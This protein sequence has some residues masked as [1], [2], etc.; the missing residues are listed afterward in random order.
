MK[1]LLTGMLTAA[2]CVS[3]ATTA[4]A[5][6]INQDSNDKTGSTTLTT[7]KA[8]TYTVVIPETAEITFDVEENPIG[9]IT[10]QSGNLEPDAYVTVELTE[11]TVLANQVDETYTIDYEIKSGDAAFE[12]IVYDEDT[13]AGTKTELT[14]NITKEAWENAKAG[15]YSATLTFTISYTNPH[16]EPEVPEEP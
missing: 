10:Y 11:Q 3:M 2:L 13:A 9:A 14:A 8:A 5:A 1:K 12:S 6:E 16:A 15:D 7:S 4:F